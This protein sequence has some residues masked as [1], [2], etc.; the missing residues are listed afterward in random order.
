MVSVAVAL[1]PERQIVIRDATREDAPRI[2]ALI[3][4]FADRNL[5]LHRSEEEVARII[6]D[7]VVAEAD[8]RIV[9]CGSLDRLEDDLAE[10]RSLAVSE[11]AQGLGVGKKL[12]QALVAKA[13]RDGFP[14]VCALTLQEKFFEKQG[15]R[16]VDRRELPPKMWGECIYCPKLYHCD[17][18]AMV[19]DL[20]Q[21]EKNAIKFARKETRRRKDA[22]AA[23]KS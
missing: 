2:A 12:V 21:T 15:F 22:K 6:E 1:S 11:D 20:D 18:I 9:G 17:E 5:M 4:H 16:V 3:N 8:G 7:F 10:I 23:K 13:R 14:R 19:M